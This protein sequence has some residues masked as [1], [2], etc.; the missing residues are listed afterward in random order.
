MSFEKSLRPYNPSKPGT[1]PRIPDSTW[2]KFR[3]KITTLHHEGYRKTEVLEV[4]KNMNFE[5]SYVKS[6]NSRCELT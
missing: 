2:E 6:L 1:A 4:L 5:P 3:E